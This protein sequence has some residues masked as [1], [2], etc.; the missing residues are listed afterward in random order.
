METG[1]IRGRSQGGGHNSYGGYRGGYENLLLAELPKA[2]PV[3]SPPDFPKHGLLTDAALGSG[4][5]KRGHAWPHTNVAHVAHVHPALFNVMVPVWKMHRE[6]CLLQE[7][8]KNT[9]VTLKDLPSL[10]CCTNPPG[11]SILR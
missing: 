5:P 3:G 2:P 7:T 8:I 10:A 1:A 4:H 9:G 11:W 6:S